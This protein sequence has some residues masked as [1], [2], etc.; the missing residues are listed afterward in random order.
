MWPVF[1]TFAESE[2][3]SPGH[4]PGGPRTAEKVT[5]NERSVTGRVCITSR[6]T[7]M[8]KM[9]VFLDLGKERHIKDV[10]RVFT[11]DLNLEMRKKTKEKVWESCPKMVQ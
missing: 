6:G 9:R 7:K 4:P 11:R 2:A 3:R 10:K 1:S 5:E 8:G